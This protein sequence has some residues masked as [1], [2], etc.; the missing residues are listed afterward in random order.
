M[1][2]VAEHC[3]KVQKISSKNAC[4]YTLL[5]IWGNYANENIDTFLAVFSHYEQIFQEKKK[6]VFTYV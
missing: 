1:C 6:L 3:N 5:T 4:L 2:S